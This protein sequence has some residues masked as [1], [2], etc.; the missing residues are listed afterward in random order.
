MLINWE[1]TRC[2]N[3]QEVKAALSGQ[4]LYCARQVLTQAAAHAAIGQ[5]NQL[6]T[7]L[8]APCCPLLAP[9]SGCR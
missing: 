3:E 2:L 6:A 7:I 5:G 4:A 1:G 9:L 8:S